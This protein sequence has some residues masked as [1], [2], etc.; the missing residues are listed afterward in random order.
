M[1]WWGEAFVK[2]VYICATSVFHGVQLVSISTADMEWL[3]QAIP[4]G[5]TSSW[6]KHAG[7][8]DCRYRVKHKSQ[9]VKQETQTFFPR[10]S[11]LW[12]QDNPQATLKSSVYAQLWLTL[13]VTL[14]LPPWKGRTIPS[15]S[16]GKERQELLHDVTMA[17][18][19]HFNYF[20]LEIRTLRLICTAWVES[21]LC[22]RERYSAFKGLQ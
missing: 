9:E 1:S 14:P 8:W 19:M 20:T 18:F 3:L 2:Y 16:D 21:C 11:E 13:T 5:L 15:S 4:Q 10:G 22:S 12:H 6:A 7:V 17:M